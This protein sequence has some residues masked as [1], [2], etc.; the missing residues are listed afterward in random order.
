MEQEPKFSDEIKKMEYEPLLPIEKILIGWSIGLGVVLLI[1]LI[2]VS[3]TF[4]Q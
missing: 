1:I 3:S 2:W 4:F